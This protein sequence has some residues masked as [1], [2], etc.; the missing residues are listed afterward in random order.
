MRGI[1]FIKYLG[2]R[3]FLKSNNPGIS[4]IKKNN[5]ISNSNSLEN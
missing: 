4:L 2:R 1:I 5:F 3:I